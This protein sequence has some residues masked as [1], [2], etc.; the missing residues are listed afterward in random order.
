[1]RF[2]L[3]RPERPLIIA[4]RHGNRIAALPPG[5][6]AIEA[7]VWLYRGRHE[8]RHRKTMGPL[9][10]LW[11]RWELAPGWRHRP[12]LEELLDALPADVPLLLDLKRLVDVEA[13]RALLERHQGRPLAV[14]SQYWGHL[15]AFEPLGIPIVYSLASEGQLRRLPAALRGRRCDALS[16]HARLLSYASVRRLRELAPALLSWPI[17]AWD[18]PWALAF[19]LDGFIADDPGAVAAALDR[20]AG[21]HHA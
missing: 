8:V 4:H 10:I 7:D 15:P 9:P 16:V 3:R 18:V 1:M 20:C 17:G 6:D 21:V 5:A 2:H 19:G 13:L 14:C 11:D 12:S